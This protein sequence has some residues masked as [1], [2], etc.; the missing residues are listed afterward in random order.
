M[1]RPMPG[2]MR[3]IGVVAV[4]CLW[5]AGAGSVFAQS[6]ETASAAAALHFRSER[7]SN[8]RYRSAEQAATLGQ[9][10]PVGQWL[11]GLDP[12][13]LILTD[14]GVV[15]AHLA[16]ERLLAR[17][18][19]EQAALL[20]LQ[21]E[22]RAESAWRHWEA[23][24][25]LDR[26]QDF[27]RDF[28]TTR[29]GLDGWLQLALRLRDGSRWSLAYSAWEQVARHPAASLRQQELANRGL[30]EA[31]E[32]LDTSSQNSSSSVTVTVDNPQPQASVTRPGGTAAWSF[33]TPLP[34]TLQGY[35]YD[36]V[37]EMQGHGV[38]V[39]PAR[40]P[41]V[42]GSELYL[43]TPTDLLA[44]DLQ[45]GAERWRNRLEDWSGI[46]RTPGH[47]DSANFRLSFLDQLGRQ[48]VADTISGGIAS[49]AERLFVIQ[50]GRSATERLPLSGPWP[51]NA[52]RDAV[53][54]PQNSLTA[55]DRATGNRLWQV[56]G[57]SFGST[58]PLG[59]LFWCGPPLVQDDL[60]YV[61][62]QQQSEL[63]LLVL[64]ADRGELVWRITLGDVPRSL[65]ADPARQRIACTPVWSQGRLYCPTAVGALVAVDP[66]TR[67][68]AW[69]RRYHVVSRDQGH[70]P[71]GENTAYLPDHWW[72][73]W[74]AVDIS[75]QQDRL[76]LVSPES[77]RLQQFS[78]TDG[79]LLWSQPRQ[80]GLYLIAADTR[81][82]IVQSAH[83]LR[84]HD[85]Q[86]GTVRWE[87][88]VPGMTGRGVLTDDRVTVPTR[89]AG[90]PSVS[91]S[92][93]ALHVDAL[94]Q[95]EFA[96]R[97][98]GNLVDGKSLWLT[99]SFE[100][101][102][103][104]RDL[105]AEARQLAEP[106]EV[107]TSEFI[108]Q[109][110]R[111]HLTRGRPDLAREQL[112]QFQKQLPESLPEADGLMFAIWLAELRQSP[113]RWRDLQ[114]ELSDRLPDLS[115]LQMVQT[116]QALALA[117][118]SQQ[119]VDAA[120]LLLSALKQAPRDRE[121]A[122]SGG[123]RHVRADLALVGEL[124]NQLAEP[125]AIA[126]AVL[127]ELRQVWQAAVDGDPFALPRLAELLRSLPAADELLI[128]LGRAPF[129]G[130]S[131]LAV[132]LR[133]LS[134]AGRVSD[135][136]AS[137]LQTQLIQQLEQAGFATE[138]R[139]YQ[140]EFA[141]HS[142]VNTAEAQTP[143]IPVPRT[144][145]NWGARTPV[146]ERMKER[147]DSV[148]YF[149]V[150]FDH[151]S[152]PFF[153]RLEMAIERQ[154]RRVRFGG[155][156]H[157]GTWDVTLPPS[158]SSFRYLQ[159]HV[160]AWGRGRVIVLRVGFELFGMTPVDER[161]EPSAQIL[162]HLDMLGGG[163]LSP[164]QLRLEISPGIS[165]IRDDDY[166]VLNGFGR[167]VGQVG[168]VRPGFLC[169]T[170]KGRLVCIDLWTGLRNWSRE[171]Q[172]PGT[173]LT[174]DDEV[175]ILWQ[176]AERL[177]TWVRAIDGALLGQRECLASTDDLFK[178]SGRHLWSTPTLQGER[179]LVCTDLA[180]GAEQWQQPLAAGT[181]VCQLA[182][183]QLGIL[184]PSGQFERR[185]ALTGLLLGTTE[186]AE[187][188]PSLD[189]IVMTHD[190]R[191]W[192][193]AVSE[194]VAQHAALQQIQLRNGYRTPFLNGRLYA[195]S[196]ESGTIEWTR[197]LEL[198]PF[199][200]DQP[201]A[202]PVLMQI[203]KQQPPDAMVG[204]LAEGVVRLIDKQS[205]RVLFEHRN[206]DLSGYATLAS[207]APNGVVTLSLE[208]ETIRL[209][210]RP[211]PPA[212]AL[213]NWD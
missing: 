77:D 61:I 69:A 63:Q 39:W 212:P 25:T 40:R 154:G 38:A 160:T 74:M 49:D 206:Q 42:I 136:A 186:L 119:P 53:Q 128:G 2:P 144:E 46:E 134:A 209:R 45:T 96:G 9:I 16:A 161:G 100:G 164:E 30:Q 159:Q 194:R 188:P 147:N 93:G 15:S 64:R 88:A 70:R 83:A 123:Q 129:L 92:D 89:D 149:A 107:A 62:G 132:E 126:N 121:L 26:L 165:G 124:A 114:A 198:E 211:R 207:D 87:T 12:A 145:S 196:R 56:G 32:Q 48:L 95:R 197:P 34:G 112:E 177:V 156:G 72:S 117:A 79:R 167:I 5:A 101:I 8:E 31:G 162:W 106:S 201:R 109:Q 180:T 135:T 58:Y 210:Y 47:L 170:E 148:H 90:L 35:W 14:D 104:W 171:N 192:Y 190:S 184:E 98:L 6:S 108:L 142:A 189:R 187:L 131:L 17:V 81:G 199:S 200:W 94:S 73:G 80:Q 181:A 19:R 168:P 195:I 174:G 152:S 169:Y 51:I 29:R 78:T 141:A 150:P 7:S 57:T 18:T 4:G 205:G 105:V 113:E 68:I 76:C 153:D 24:P 55:Y 3:M 185:H 22:P 173:L 183:H 155:G 163:T 59:N 178:L 102:S 157:A 36:W 138:A 84:Q 71:R 99:A 97:G 75:I 37:Q 111:H 175:V 1:R 127:Q 193:L 158:P 85:W 151:D 191:N 23:E 66:L 130:Q 176:P 54:D 204:Q 21:Q 115:P 41:V 182:G 143:S 203:F 118:G 50:E 65:G 122:L 13:E 91:L 20:L 43:R 60:L 202:A 120:R 110:V 86:T 52:G 11:S 208:R 10:G 28:G 179:R 140:R 82:P 172:P 103:A 133:L 27:C 116:Q 33:P 166:R 139:E 146:V 125:P 44:L 213:P 137:Q 67:S